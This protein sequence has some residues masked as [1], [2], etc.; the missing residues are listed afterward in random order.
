MKLFSFQGLIMLL[1]YVAVVDRVA[2]MIP[3]IPYVSP[4]G[5]EGF[6]LKVSGIQAAIPLAVAALLVTMTP[7]LF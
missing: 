1:V 5:A 6:D 4:Y 3:A 7:K 2:T